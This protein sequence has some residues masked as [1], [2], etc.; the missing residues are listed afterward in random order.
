MKERR[1]HSTDIL[2]S[3]LVSKLGHIIVM[4]TFA[5]LCQ[6]TYKSI[7]VYI[8]F[9]AVILANN[10]S[11]F[12]MSVL[13]KYIYLWFR[14]ISWGNRMANGERVLIEIRTGKKKFGWTF[15]LEPLGNC[16]L[17]R[18]NQWE[19]EAWWNGIISVQVC[20]IYKHKAYVCNW[21]LKNPKV[22]ASYCFQ[23]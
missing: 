16:M 13:W 11:I 2:H 18:V 17:F 23:F 6:S 8:C 19:T 3:N 20:Q 9:R 21:T 15:F 4:T 5:F 12:V 14:I 7:S 10:I 1:T 22:P